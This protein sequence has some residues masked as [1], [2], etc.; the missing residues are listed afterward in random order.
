[1]KKITF[2]IIALFIGL[3]FGILF[4]PVH[5]IDNAPKINSQD[6]AV[7]NQQ[8]EL[9]KAAVIKLKEQAATQKSAV[10]A[11]PTLILNSDDAAKLRQTLAALTDTLLAL[12]SQLKN[13]KLSPQNEKAIIER[14]AAITN[15][16]TAINFTIKNSS[17]VLIEKKS[18]PSLSSETT[19]TKIEQPAIADNETQAITEIPSAKE[20]RQR[21]ASIG[22]IFSRNRISTISIIISLIV[23]ASG[24]WLWKVKFSGKEIKTK[25]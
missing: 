15:G 17:L 2:G 11:K 14:L 10:V 21:F 3:N 25:Q 18:V 5:A 12:Q 20:D 8:I 24:I 22:T 6:A 7:L 4:L 23:A 19:T 16:L 1:M 9:M 13:N